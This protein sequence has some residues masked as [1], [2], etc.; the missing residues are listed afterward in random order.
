[1]STTATRSQLSVR[2]GTSDDDAIC[3]HIVGAAAS[4]A[5]YAPRLPHAAGALADVSPVELDGRSRMVAVIAGQVIGFADYR[6]KDGHIKYL[7]V[8]P[9]A[10]G[11]GAGRALVDAVQARVAGSISVNVLAVN[12][13]GILWY[14]RRGFAVTGGW[15]EPFE[16]VPAAWLRMERRPV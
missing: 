13:Q 2:E 4:A 14:L 6:A 11:T 1:M 9:H 3:G 7:F 16:G 5:V 15:E 8:H 12:D 10:Q